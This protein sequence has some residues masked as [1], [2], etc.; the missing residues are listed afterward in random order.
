MKHR[1]LFTL[2]E[3]VSV[4]VITS[5]LASGMTFMV[6]D[7]SK[8]YLLFQQAVEISLDKNYGLMRLSKELNL[9]NPAVT[10]TATGFTFGNNAANISEVSWDSANEQLLIDGAVML[11][12]V[13]DFQVS[14]TGK[15]LTIGLDIRGSGLISTTV[16]VRN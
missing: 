9:N 14:Q 11:D 13:T 16:R 1:N 8:S 3:L 15:L 6:V 7:L 4:I 2:I 12:N 5:I 10:L